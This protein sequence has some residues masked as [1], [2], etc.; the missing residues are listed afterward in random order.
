MITGQPQSFEQFTVMQHMP[1]QQFQSHGLPIAAEQ[2]YYNAQ[3]QNQN[4]IQYHSHQV[5]QASVDAYATMGSQ[6][7]NPQHAQPAAAEEEETKKRGGAAAT[8]SNEKELRASLE[9]NLH[10]T[11]KDV[12]KEVLDSERTTR[13][14]KTKQLFAMLW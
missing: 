1:Q 11:L 6:Q 5:R 10:R 13:A 7:M 8:Q 12:A 3:L 9:Q 2:Q 4:T 14:E